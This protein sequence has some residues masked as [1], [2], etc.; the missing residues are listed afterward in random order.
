MQVNEEADAHEKPKLHDLCNILNVP[1]SFS[2][3]PEANFLIAPPECDEYDLVKHLQFRYPKKP[4]GDMNFGLL[5]D[6]FHMTS[7]D[8]FTTKRSHMLR[9]GLLV[10]D[11]NNPNNPPWTLHTWGL[12][13]ISAFSTD[14]MWIMLNGFRMDRA[15]FIIKRTIALLSMAIQWVHVNERAD[16]VNERADVF[17]SLPCLV[18]CSDIVPASFVSKL[19]DEWERGISALA[20][21][22]LHVNDGKANLIVRPWNDETWISEPLAHNPIIYPVL[23]WIPYSDAVHV[24]QYKVKPWAKTFKVSHEFWVIMIHGCIQK[25]EARYYGEAFSNGWLCLGKMQCFRDITGYDTWQTWATYSI[26]IALGTL[27]IHL[28]PRKAIDGIKIQLK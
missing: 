22:W 11:T 17:L 8:L 26:S 5:W 3:T 25:E 18:D 9:Y 1:L 4:M 21:S 10:K 28:D 12:Q 7:Y 15:L 20:H 2:G 27:F 6:K 19:K 14:A 13:L 23:H 24:L 16:H